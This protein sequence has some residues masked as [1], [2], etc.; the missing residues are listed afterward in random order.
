MD[1]ANPAGAPGSTVLDETETVAITRCDERIRIGGMAERGGFDLRLDP[2]RRG[3]LDMVVRDLFPHA[4]IRR[5]PAS[6]PA[7]AR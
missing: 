2:R 7:C 3:T 5:V 6:G 4:G 1:L